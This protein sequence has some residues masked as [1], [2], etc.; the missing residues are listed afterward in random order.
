[1]H[2]ISKLISF[3][4]KLACKQQHQ[5]Q[6]FLARHHLI[7]TALGCESAAV[8]ARPRSVPM[9]TPPPYEHRGPPIPRPVN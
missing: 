2:R 6:V 8:G 5:P 9:E 1:M 3:I 7:D 4:L